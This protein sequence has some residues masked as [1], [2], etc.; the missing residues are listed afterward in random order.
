M[1]CFHFKVTFL[2]VFR[3]EGKRVKMQKII[4]AIAVKHVTRIRNNERIALF[5]GQKTFS[6]YTDF[7]I[8]T[9]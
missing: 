4:L 8:C 2:Y 6:H 5:V 9:F 1:E 3:G 7:R